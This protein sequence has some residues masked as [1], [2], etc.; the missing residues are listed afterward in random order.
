M[1]DPKQKM[2]LYVFPVMILL[3]SV[4]FQAGLLLYWFTNSLISIGNHFLLKRVES[5]K[6]EKETRE[7]IAASREDSLKIG[8][9]EDNT[10]KQEAAIKPGKKKKVKAAQKNE[11]PKVK[12]KSTKGKKKGAG[13]AR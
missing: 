10:V 5:A 4:N 12:K 3:I 11:L 7:T 1:T 8:S 2:M 9:V 13:K 6:S